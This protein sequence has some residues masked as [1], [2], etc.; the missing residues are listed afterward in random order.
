M[1]QDRAGTLDRLEVV[2]GWILRVGVAASSACLA[3]GLALVLVN[4][5]DDVSARLLAVGIVV[6]LA[7]PVARVAASMVEYAAGRDWAFATFTAVVLLE[8]MLG[9]AVAVYTGR[10]L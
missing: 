5:G 9:V 1:N 8:L 4:V 3:A 6:M 2:I 7:T 10:S